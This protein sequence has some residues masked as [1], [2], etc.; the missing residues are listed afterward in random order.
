[1]QHHLRG[2]QRLADTKRL[3]QPLLYDGADFAVLHV[4]L[5]ASEGAVDAEPPAPAVERLPGHVDEGIGGRKNVGHAE[6]RHFEI[7]VFLDQPVAVP[8]KVER[9]ELRADDGQVGHES[10]PP[11]ARLPRKKVLVPPRPVWGGT[12][13]ARARRS[14]RT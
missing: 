2:P 7:A 14:G 13:D 1:M 3:V 11:V 9:G 12:S 10:G 5:E 6:F 8:G 4:Q